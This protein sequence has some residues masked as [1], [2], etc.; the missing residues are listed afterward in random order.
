MSLIQETL[1][2]FDEKFVPASLKWKD[3]VHCTCCT[4]EEE[5]NDIKSFIREEM[6]GLVEKLKT[7][8]AGMYKEQLDKNDPD[9]YGACYAIGGFNDALNKV[10][11]KL[12][13]L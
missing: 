11:T 8:L 13:E 1:K 12:K 9:N 4:T 3:A 10:Q 7:E 6:T 5:Y 2:N